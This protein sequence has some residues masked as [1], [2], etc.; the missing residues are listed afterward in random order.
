MEV[1]MNKIETMRRIADFLDAWDHMLECSDKIKCFDWEFE[2]KITSSKD[3]E[4]LRDAANKGI[5]EV[6]REHGMLTD[7]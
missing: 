2:V 4:W 5:N 6:F 3:L 1:F 7:E